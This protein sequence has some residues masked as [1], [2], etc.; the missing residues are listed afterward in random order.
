M[1]ALRLEQ[2]PIL[3]IGGMTY[4]DLIG[5]SYPDFVKFAEATGARGV[6]IDDP[7]TGVQRSKALS[8]VVGRLRNR[9]ESKHPE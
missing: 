6:C 9:A 3:A 1:E 2:A 5:T 4:H 7:T 8:G